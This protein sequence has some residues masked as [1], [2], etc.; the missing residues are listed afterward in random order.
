VYLSKEETA[1]SIG[2]GG[3]EL[4]L[5]NPAAKPVVPLDTLCIFSRFEEGFTRFSFTGS[6]ALE[7]GVTPAGAVM[8]LEG[9]EGAGFINGTWAVT[10]G[11]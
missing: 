9:E 5:G 10:A 2:K 3:C 7:E 4:E 11:S 6:Y 1:E 8:W